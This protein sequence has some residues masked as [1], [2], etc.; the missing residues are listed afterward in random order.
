MKIHLFYYLSGVN[1]EITPVQKVKKYYLIMPLKA[2][3]W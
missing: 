3:F 2:G 1:G